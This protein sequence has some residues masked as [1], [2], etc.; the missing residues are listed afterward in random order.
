M[1]TTELKELIDGVI[2]D[3]NPGDAYLAMAKVGHEVSISFEGDVDT[4]VASLVKLMRKYDDLA[5]VVCMA[6][7]HYEMEGE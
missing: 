7:D 4:I 3:V 2:V 1:N 5:T 6:A